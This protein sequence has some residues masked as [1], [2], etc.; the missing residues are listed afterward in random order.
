VPL[1]QFLDIPL[2]DAARIAKTD[3]LFSD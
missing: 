2:E 3:H 1:A